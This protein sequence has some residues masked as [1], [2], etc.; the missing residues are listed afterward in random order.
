[1]AN[2]AEDAAAGFNKVVDTLT[3]LRDTFKATGVAF[4]G[5]DGPSG[6]AQTGNG[7]EKSTS[8]EV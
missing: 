3:N 2:I 7:I 4:S 1:M 8:R 6:I 5:N